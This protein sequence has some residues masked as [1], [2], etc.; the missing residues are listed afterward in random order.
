MLREAMDRLMSASKQQARDLDSEKPTRIF[1]DNLSEL[2]TSKKIAVKDLTAAEPKEVSVMSTM[3]G[4]MD[5]EYYYLLPNVAFGAVQKLCREQGIEFPVSLKA[6]YKHL[7]TDG[8][9]TVE[10]S[11]EN[12]T[13]TKR[14]DGK[15]PRLLWIP[16]TALDGPKAENKQ[17]KMID[18][19]GQVENPFET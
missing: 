9:L 11:G 18:V 7:K 15:C 19:T 2:M 3:V 16:A 13:K 14:I 12:M 6:L 17:E 1:L 10:G 4:Y 5:A 8:I